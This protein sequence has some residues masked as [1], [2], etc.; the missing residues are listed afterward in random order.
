[1]RNK[2]SC[3]NK[4]FL[5]STILQGASGTLKLAKPATIEKKDKKEVVEK[6]K[7]VKKDK[8]EKK[9]VVAKVYFRTYRRV[10]SSECSKPN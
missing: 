6:E 9:V 5:F 7:S 10:L 8:K 4:L 1:M 3:W 2:K